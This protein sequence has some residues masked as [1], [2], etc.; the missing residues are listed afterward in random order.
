M[1][2]THPSE[3]TPTSAPPSSSQSTLPNPTNDPLLLA[4]TGPT[5][6]GKT[7]LATAL[8]QIFPPPYSLTIHADDFYKPDSLVPV[9]DGVQDWDCAGAMDLEKFEGVLRAVK[10]WK[11]DEGLEGL[12]GLLRQGNFEGEEGPMDGVHGVK[13]ISAGVV[14]RLRR[15]VEGWEERVRRGRRIV[16]VDGFL[17]VGK[18]VR[19]RIAG[20]CDVRVLLTARFEDA[21]TRRESRNGYVTLEGF[22]EDPEGYFD[23]VVWPN[24]VH[25]HGYLFEEGDVEG[26]V[27]E[28]RR[29]EEGVVILGLGL[30]LEE[31]LE[32]V[33]EELKKALGD[34]AMTEAPGDQ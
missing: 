2:N 10:G 7:T 6:S 23:R 32:R 34:K 24:Y 11:G 30:T 27:D 3:P 5:S 22:W 14:E 17:L 33:V 25:E 4:L 20:L 19:E 9:K 12:Q 18:S 15:E 26:I 1:S 29:R 8:R 31:M 16:I 21:K 28:V 13:G